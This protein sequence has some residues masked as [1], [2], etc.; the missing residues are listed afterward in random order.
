MSNDSLLAAVRAAA[1]EPASAVD[2][3]TRQP[4]EHSMAGTQNDPATAPAKVTSLAELRAAFPDLCAQIQTES[5][6]AGANAERERI[7][8]I[9]K[10]GASMKGH[11]ALISE[12]KADGKTTPEQAAVR[13][14]AAEG[15]LRE[16]QLKGVKDVESLTG[17]VPASPT[18][19]GAAAP[20]STEKP[21]TPEGWKTEF[22]SSQALQSEFGSVERYV[23]FKGAEASGKVRF[24]KNKTA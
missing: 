19:L 1:N 21:A 22:E 5:M 13:I 14:V 7:G 23:T 8:G 11:D 16:Q 3:S 4:Q 12:M 9:E 18:S 24:L 15:A 2:A 17:K 10:L 20:A 6:S